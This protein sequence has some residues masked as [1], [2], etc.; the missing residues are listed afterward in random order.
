MKVSLNYLKKYI[1]FDLPQIS[2]LINIIGSQLGAIEEQP[3]NLAEVYKDV[4]IVKII[5]SQKIENSDH[6]NSCLIDDGRKIV[7]IE[8]DDNGYISVVCGAPNVKEGILAAWLPPGSVVPATFYKEKLVLETRPIRGSVS[9]GMLASPKELALYDDH[10]GILVINDDVK[11]GDNFCQAYDL[12]DVIIDIENKM[13]T[14]RPDCFGLLG[15][16]R[17]VSGILDHPFKSPSWYIKGEL[18]N[19]NNFDE[20]IKINNEIPSLVPRFSVVVIDHIKIEPSPIKIQTYLSRLGIRPINNIVDLTNLIMIETGQPLHAY[21]Y[22][23]LQKIMADDQTI[24]IRPPK[25]NERAQLINGKELTPNQEAITIAAG[26]QIIGLGGVMGGTNSEIDNQTT[27][28]VLESASFDMFKIRRTSMELGIFSDAV[29]RFTK[30]Q[31]PLQTVRVLSYAL[32]KILDSVPGSKQATK[33]IDDNH[34]AEVIRKRDSLN[35]E[36][37][38]NLDFINQRLGTQLTTQEVIKILTN[39]ECQIENKDNNLTVKAPFWRTDLEIREDIVE[40][41]GRLYGYENI[42]SHS[43][44]REVKP[45]I[46]NANLELKSNIRQLLSSVGANEL[47]THSFVSRKLIENTNQSADQAYQIANSLSPELNYYRLSLTPSL[48]SKVQ[49]NAKAGF[50]EFAIFEIG[51]YHL[52]DRFNDSAVSD[53]N[54]TE[55]QSVALVYTTA[56]PVKSATYFKAKQFLS[57]LIDKLNILDVK[58][59][60]LKDVSEIDDHL[61]QVVKPFDINR[62]ALVIANDKQWG[63]VGE[64]QKNVSTKL[65]LISSTAGF[66]VDTRLFQLGQ[67]D[68]VYKRLSRYPAVKQDITLQVNNSVNYA[69]INQLLISALNE[70]V[71][72]HSSYSLAPLSIYS[73][74]NNPEKLNYTFHLEISSYL[75]TLKEQEVNELLDKVS[76]HANNKFQAI[77]V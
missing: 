8:R 23:K 38:V 63:I 29:T 47:L 35:P 37:T 14:H 27:A 60:P 61:S 46:K 76:E 50:K 45:T 17:E 62:S 75:R 77:R 34:L 56:K 19:Q 36:I 66:E 11:P 65:K 4:I 59:V 71:P 39:V 64:Y 15:I 10:G 28:I 5:K 52:I 1:D 31:S 33:I 16:A 72:D 68:K 6:L 44:T 18:T 41:V 12:D 26:N 48:L 22:H 67:S 57:Y 21:D 58:F 73:P 69:D 13:F 42:T 43:L 32:S 7:D 9:H 24:T 25:P 20:D 74:D 49:I 3:V 51:T 53:T 54:I 30:G 70:I 40:E 55:F 2:Q